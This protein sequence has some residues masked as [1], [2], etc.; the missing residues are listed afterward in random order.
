MRRGIVYITGPLFILMLLF[1][2]AG[3]QKQVA[4]GRHVHTIDIKASNY[5]F[6]P[7][8]IKVASDMVTFRISNTTRKMHNFTLK[9]P[10]GK[11]ME[12]VDIPPETTVTVLVTFRQTGTYKFYCDRPFHALL[13]MRGQVQSV[14]K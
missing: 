2:C 12:N 5:K 14:G 3:L 10:E 7:D 6:E 4:L 9:D 8:N 13:G 11:I 1:S